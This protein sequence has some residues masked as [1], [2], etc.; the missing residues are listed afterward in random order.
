M[1]SEATGLQKASLYHRY[2]GGKQEMAEHVLSLRWT[3]LGDH[4]IAH[5]NDDGPPE[6]RLAEVNRSLSTFYEAGGR[7]AC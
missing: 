3:G 6:G 4:V 5:L 1:L 7:L 2:P